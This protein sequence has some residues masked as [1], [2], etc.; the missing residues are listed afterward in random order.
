MNTRTLCQFVHCLLSKIG[1]IIQRK[2][3]KLGILCKI[4]FKYPKGEKFHGYSTLGLLYSANDKFAEFTFNLFTWILTI[5]GTGNL[6][7]AN[8]KKMTATN[9]CLFWSR[10]VNSVPCKYFSVTEHV[11]SWVPL[12]LTTNWHVWFQKYTP[13]YSN[14]KS[15][16]ISVFSSFWWKEL[17]CHVPCELK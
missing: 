5:F 9:K 7:T 6:N 11:L 12:Q 14:I 1:Q 15:I 17:T 13:Q 8:S 2:W 10:L 16:F 4:S 3:H